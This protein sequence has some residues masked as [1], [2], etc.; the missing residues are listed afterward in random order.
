MEDAGY[1]QAQKDVLYQRLYTAARQIYEHEC[2]IIDMSFSKGPIKGITA[3]QMKHF[4]ES[5]IDLCLQ[6]L[7]LEKIYK[8]TYNPIAKWFYRMIGGDTQHDFFYKLGSSYNR[9][10]QEKGF[11]WKIGGIDG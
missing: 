9:D 10:W 2:R 11:V 7:G 6:N 5:R 8:P 3:K 1:T 4:V